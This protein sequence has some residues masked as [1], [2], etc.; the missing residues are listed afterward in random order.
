MTEEDIKMNTRSLS[1]G[2]RKRLLG[3]EWRWCLHLGF[4]FWCA[5]LK[6]FYRSMCQI[7]LYSSV[8]NT[9]TSF[10]RPVIVL[11][12]WYEG[13]KKVVLYF[14]SRLHVERITRVNKTVQFARIFVSYIIAYI[15]AMFLNLILVSAYF[16]S[17][18]IRK[19]RIFLFFCYWFL[20]QLYLK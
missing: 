3:R 17:L 20:I 12:C 4:N 19:S 16:Y 13:T 1:Q 18:H 10:G 9:S 5:W 14:F 8:A 6:Y 7:Y 11:F 2:Y 15:N